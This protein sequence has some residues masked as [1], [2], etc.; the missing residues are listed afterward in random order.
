MPSTAIRSYSYDAARRELT[1]TFVTGRR[2]L[3]FDVPAGAADG[4]SGATSKG[5]YFNRVIRG[6]YRFVELASEAA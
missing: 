4:L 2:Y 3:Y 1:V 5:G 6:A